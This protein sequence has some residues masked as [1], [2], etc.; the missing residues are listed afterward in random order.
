MVSTPGGW[1]ATDIGHGLLASPD[2][3]RW[4][5]VV[6][7]DGVALAPAGSGAIAGV[8]TFVETW[9]AALLVSADGTEWRRRAVTGPAGAGIDTV[10]F[11]EDTFIALG[12]T[13]NVPL[14]QPPRVGA[15][16]GQLPEPEPVHSFAGWWSHEGDRWHVGRI[17]AAPGHPPGDAG[18][19]I[20]PFAG[21]MVA[22]RSGR[23]ALENGTVAVWW[24][25]NGS[26]WSLLPGELPMA[27]YNTAVVIND[28]LLVFGPGP[29]DE[30]VV[31]IGEAS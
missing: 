31:W 7:A 12:W 10:A 19:V 28:Q 22:V 18:V 2:G 8:V 16:D 5:T 6:A 27:D 9:E 17:Q 25:T 29:D 26:S 4:S 23:G 20:V 11:V 13:V 21:G 15:P 24:S 14:T 30:T 3:G 1:L